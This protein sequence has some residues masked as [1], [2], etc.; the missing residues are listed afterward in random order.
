LSLNSRNETTTV[1]N[2]TIADYHT[3]AVGF[4]ETL[5][6]NKAMEAGNIPK[7]VK[8]P[9][10]SEILQPRKG[11]IKQ[12]ELPKG[13]PSWE[14]VSQMTMAEVEAAAKANKPGYKTIKKLLED[15]RFKR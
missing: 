1:Y 15:N 11:S 14:K 8:S 2:L 3:Y 9:L 13:S 12:A 10:V 7:H 5:V 6:H 4:G